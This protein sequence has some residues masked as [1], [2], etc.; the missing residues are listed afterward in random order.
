MGCSTLLTGFCLPDSG[1]GRSGS[2][3]QTEITLPGP[4][5]QRQTRL[6]VQMIR[7]KMILRTFRPRWRVIKARPSA[8]SPP[9]PQRSSSSLP[10]SLHSKVTSESAALLQRVSLAVGDHKKPR[11]R[12]GPSS[13]CRCWT[14]RLQL[15]YSRLGHTFRCRERPWV[16]AEGCHGRE[17]AQRRA[18]RPPHSMQG[19]H[20]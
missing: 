13:R 5:M 1:A 10:R 8:P 17:M 6:W 12:Q 3:F 20:S 18:G 15:A 4:P 2:S 19:R 16:Q 14:G 9:R 11:R 7:L